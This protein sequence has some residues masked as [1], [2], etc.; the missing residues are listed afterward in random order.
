MKSSTF[1]FA[2]LI[3]TITSAAQPVKKHGK[4]HVDGLQLKDEKGNMANITIGDVYQSNGVIHV[5]DK[6]VMPR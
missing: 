3:L 4:L 6:V 5:I 1:L 2:L